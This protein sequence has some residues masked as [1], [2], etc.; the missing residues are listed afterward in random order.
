[1]EYFK[2]VK[3]RATARLSLT[4]KTKKAISGKEVLVYPHLVRKPS[5]PYIGRFWW[6]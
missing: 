6:R 3:T 5:Q 2:L 1:M 4:R